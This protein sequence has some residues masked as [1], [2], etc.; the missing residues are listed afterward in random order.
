MYDALQTKLNVTFRK[1]CN[2]PFSFLSVICF[3]P[4][5]GLFSVCSLE[6]IED[7]FSFW[8]RNISQQHLKGVVIALHLISVLR[9]VSIC[10]FNY[11]LPFFLSLPIG[12]RVLFK[13]LCIDVNNPDR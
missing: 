8:F 1:M 13:I 7:G 9:R 3:P 11:T 6:G 2:L 12:T 4:F 10:Y 5:A